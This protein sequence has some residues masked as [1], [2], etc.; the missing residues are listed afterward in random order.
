MTLDPA[1]LAPQPRFVYEAVVDLLPD[2]AHGDVP[3]GQR[4][5]VP[6]IGGWFRGPGLSGEV[7]PGGADW[8]ILREDGRLEL[9]AIYDMRTDDGVC[10]HVRNRALWYSANG[11]WPAEYA[12][13]APIIEAPSSGPLAWFNH[14]LFTCT[15]NPVPGRQAVHLH[16]YALDMPQ[17][18][19]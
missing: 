6:I 7:L 10:L 16:V 14:T 8:Q 12:V 18:A 17:N 13:G 5:T 1:R 11:D 9:E 3:R 4:I 2:R 15:V 19:A